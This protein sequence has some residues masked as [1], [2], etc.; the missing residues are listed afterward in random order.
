MCHPI[1]ISPWNISS[2]IFL[3]IADAQIP[4]DFGRDIWC[5]IGKFN[6]Y[7]T[8]TVWQRTKNFYEK[9]VTTI[10]KT[11]TKWIYRG[12]LDKYQ[13]LMDIYHVLIVYD[14]FI[15]NWREIKNFSWVQQGIPA[16]N[17][18]RN[19]GACSWSK[20]ARSRDIL[21]SPPRSN[22]KR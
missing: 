15:G 11:V 1:V 2:R 8:T 6:V 14:S 5:C 22:S 12:S 21:S 4:L 3:D 13:G 7:R 19:C 18:E 16:A 9:Y 17:E 20:R 10:R